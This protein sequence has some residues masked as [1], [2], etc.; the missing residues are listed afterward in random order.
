ML[1]HSRLEAVYR[2]YMALRFVSIQF[3][4]YGLKNLCFCSELSEKTPENS[5]A[6]FRHVEGIMDDAVAAIMH[7][8]LCPQCMTAAMTIQMLLPLVAYKTRTTSNFRRTVS[9][10]SS[11]INI[12]VCF[13]IETQTRPPKWTPL[14]DQLVTIIQTVI[15]QCRKIKMV[16]KRTRHLRV[17]LSEQAGLVLELRTKMTV[18]KLQYDFSPARSSRH[19]TPYNSWR[20][21]NHN[22]LQEF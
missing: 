5:K 18:M 22:T 15:I 14:L 11:T 19:Q 1:Q 13:S 4:L 2:D 9:Y 3:C 6:N 10:E 21:Y 20:P 12:L 16:W 8:E 17:Q 7:Q